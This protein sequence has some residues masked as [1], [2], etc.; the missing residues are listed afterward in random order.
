MLFQLRKL[1]GVLKVFTVFTFIVFIIGSVSLYL[2]KVSKFNTHYFH[3]LFFF[4]WAWFVIYYYTLFPVKWPRLIMAIVV[5]IATI[6]FVAYYIHN[7]PGVITQLGGP[8]YFVSTILILGFSLS[9][10]FYNLTQRKSI[11]YYFI[12]AGVLIFYS[13]HSVIFLFGNYLLLVTSKKLIY[14]WM[15]NTLLHIVFLSLI[16]IEIWKQVYPNKKTLSR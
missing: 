7:W 8:L 10:Y 13:G 14:L 4:Q 2:A 6:I 16:F 1:S 5:G 15:F 3:L 11:R 12:N 9:Y